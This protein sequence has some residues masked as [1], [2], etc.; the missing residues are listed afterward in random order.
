MLELCSYSL[1]DLLDSRGHLTHPE[2]R[3]N[4]IQI[5]GGIK[6][7]HKHGLIHCDINP[8]NILVGRDGYLKIS[9]FGLAVDL[10]TS[11]DESPIRGTLR[12]MAPELLGPG[13]EFGQSM[14][15]WSVGVSM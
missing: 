14:D 2:V 11:R 3:M 10:Q 12:Y 7:I 5:L 6:H 1:E 15:I 9:D 13:K 4:T 8:K